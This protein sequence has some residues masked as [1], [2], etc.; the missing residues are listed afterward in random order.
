MDVLCDAILHFKNTNV[1]PM[2]LLAT[3][4]EKMW[5][6]RIHGISKAINL[7]GRFKL[8]RR[9]GDHSVNDYMERINQH[10]FID[11]EDKIGVSSTV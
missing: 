8:E 3:V 9:I 2:L 11:V 7:S 4:K 6:S 5:L 1:T 10:G